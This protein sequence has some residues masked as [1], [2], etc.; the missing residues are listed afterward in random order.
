[1]FNLSE[2]IRKLRLENVLSNVQMADIIG[3]EARTYEKIE[4]DLR[5]LKLSEIN[6][7]CKHFNIDPQEFI[8]GTAK[9][10]FE[11]CS[12]I[13]SDGH[14]KKITVASNEPAILKQFYDDALKTKDELINAQKIVIQILRESNSKGG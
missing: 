12:Y 1:M 10:V 4:H 9:L 13:S 2:K 5:E 11:N 3:I 7:F 6:T 14:N 8:F